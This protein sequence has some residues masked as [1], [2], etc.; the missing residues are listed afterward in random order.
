V[1]LAK[2]KKA[3]IKN[4]EILNDNINE[5]KSKNKNST[6]AVLPKLDTK[7]KL[8]DDSEIISNVIMLSENDVPNNLFSSQS[9]RVLPMINQSYDKNLILNTKVRRDSLGD[10]KVSSVLP[11]ITLEI[12]R[13]LTTLKNSIKDQKSSIGL[14]SLSQLSEDDYDNEKNSNNSIVSFSNSTITKNLPKQTA[15]PPQLPKKLREDIH[16]KAI[17]IKAKVNY[18]DF[19]Y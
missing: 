12:S 9:L 7:Y 14:F 18:F 16:L 8:R 2:M 1:Q 17:M 10:H 3:K 13:N 11:E 6:V 5:I 15:K 19:H 4:G